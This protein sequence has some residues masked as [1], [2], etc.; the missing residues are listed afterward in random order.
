MSSQH[1][2]FRIV[3]VSGPICSGKSALSSQLKDNHQATIVRTK[4]FILKR[5]P[6]T[7]PHRHAM[8]LAGQQ[9]D[10][11]DG[12][13]WVCEELQEEIDRLT[14]SGQ[15]PV[16][17]YV[18]DSVRIRG[19]IDA[20]RQA[21]GSEVFHVHLTA[22]SDELQERFEERKGDGDSG[23][24]YSDLKKNQTEKQV[25]K[26]AEVADIVVATDKCSE[27]AVLVRATALLNLYP[28]SS[29]ALVDVIIGGQYGSEG[30]GNIVGHLASE[31][32]LLVRVGGPNA[33]HQVYNEPQPEKYYHL[34]SGTVR[35]PNALL[36]L[37]PGAVINP[38][39]L[40]EEVAEHQ[41]T[42]KR[43][44]ID[45]QAVIIRKDDIS[46]E[47]ELFE[48]IS[49]TA[50]GVGI[51]SARKIIGR[52]NYKSKK[53]LFLAKDCDELKLYIDNTRKVIADALVKGKHILLEGTQGTSLSLHHG[54]YPHVTS[55]DTTVAGCLSDAGIA[56]S[57]V[58]KVILVCRTYPIRVGG[59]SGDMKY[60]VT[61]QDI[62]TRSNILLEELERTE[63]TTTTNRRRRIA[64]FDWEQFRDSV[65]LNG[66]TD[67]ALTFVDYL[68]IKN[69]SAFRFEQ[70]NE[71]TIRFVEELERVSGRPVSLL[72][73][74]F[75]WRNIID[76]RTW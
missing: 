60:E 59:P 1:E 3:L 29:D 46:E 40:L 16:G 56:P 23:M 66:P 45:P 43:L 48:N 21:Y 67:I 49:S 4:D 13:A 72:S 11:I 26:L 18:V 54:Q 69:R 27:G 19:Q 73:T 71:E 76:R 25:D 37:G 62:H 31:Y 50:Q 8:Q 41:I 22:N 70:L 36:L 68:G 52:S 10:K 65:Q 9:L 5:K 61:L 42:H 30:K 63:T 57:H 17:L 2:P 12:G 24:D 35:A 32:D 38:T 44:I 53:D 34:P 74:D 58:R 15:T 55:R 47:K 20:I 7:K 14:S 39:K 75:N 33:G 51:A 28:R 64:E 6:R